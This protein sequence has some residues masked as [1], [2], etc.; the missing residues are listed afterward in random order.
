MGR[1]GGGDEED[2]II[3][4]DR[5]LRNARIKFARTLDFREISRRSPPRRGSRSVILFFFSRCAI[6]IMHTVARRAGQPDCVIYRMEGATCEGRDFFYLVS[7]RKTSLA[8]DV[9]RSID[10]QRTRGSA[11]VASLYRSLS[12]LLIKLRMNVYKQVITGYYGHVRSL[13]VS[14]VSATK[15][16]REGKKV[17]S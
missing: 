5:R 13:V 8:S 6:K 16:E 12:K 15:L 1:G 17:I 2:A 10:A 7:I 9:P 4:D 3:A 11:R 14:F